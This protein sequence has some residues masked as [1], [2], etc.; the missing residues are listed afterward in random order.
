MKSRKIQNKSR[1]VWA[2]IIGTAI[3]VIGFMFT[4]MIAYLQFQRVTSLQDP[5]SYQIFQDKLQYTLF[6]ADICEEDT[7][8]KISQDLTFQGQIIGDLENKLGLDN[9][10]VLF[11]KKFYTLIQLEHFEFVKLINEECDKNINSILFFYS[12]KKADLKNSE[13]LGDILG[14]VYQRNKDTLV[15]YSLDLNLDSE[16]MKSLRKK[17]NVGEESVVIVNENQRFTKINHINEIEQF[18]K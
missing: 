17:Y 5:I 3:F 1:Y 11:R 15:L 16:I 9:P 4:N 13:K 7:Y 6:G 14:S 2:F 12:N 18:L 10:G 8:I